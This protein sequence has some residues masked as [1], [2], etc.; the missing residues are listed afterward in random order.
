MGVEVAAQLAVEGFDVP[1]V[2]DGDTLGHASSSFLV[3]ILAHDG[4]TNSQIR[5]MID[6]SE[7]ASSSS[8]AA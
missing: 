3:T 8:D 1:D 5:S 7:T 6:S 2:N 4:L